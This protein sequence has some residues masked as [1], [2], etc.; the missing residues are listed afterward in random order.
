[1]KIPHVSPASRSHLAHSLLVYDYVS[2]ITSACHRRP[3]HQPLRLPQRP[4][5]LH[6]RPLRL[7]QRVLRLRL[8]LPVVRPPTPLQTHLRA[9]HASGKWPVHAAPQLSAL[10][11]NVL[12]S[13]LEDC[14]CTRVGCSCL[15]TG[16]FRHLIH[17]LIVLHE[18]SVELCVMCGINPETFHTCF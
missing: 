15:T 11:R 17:A 10:W 13:C 6:Q 14:W 9:G 18:F 2:M 4:L 5:H 1:M 7:P 8:H 3:P 16:R 12:H